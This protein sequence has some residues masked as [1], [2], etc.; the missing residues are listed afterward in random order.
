MPLRNRFVLPVDVFRTDG[1]KGDL[2]F[3]TQSGVEF[4]EKAAT[5]LGGGASAGNGKSMM[6]HIDSQELITLP[7]DL[8]DT[9]AN[10]IGSYHRFLVIGLSVGGL[11]AALVIAWRFSQLEMSD[12]LNA[13][14]ILLAATIFPEGVPLHFS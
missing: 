9:F 8:S 14:L 6:C 4:H 11:A 3:I 2:V 10:F 1:L 12:S 13:T 5:V 7:A